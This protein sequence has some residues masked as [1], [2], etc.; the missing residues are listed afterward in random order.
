MN[1][2]FQY[3]IQNDGI[4]TGL[5]YPYEAKDSTCRFRRDDPFYQINDISI[6]P[7]N[8]EQALKEALA[9]KGPVAVAID[10]SGPFHHYKNGVFYNP[11]CE[12]NKFR[13]AVLVVGY[14]SE[15]REDFW[16]VKNSWGDKWGEQGYIKMARN[17]NNNC[18]IAGVASFPVVI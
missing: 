10:S 14:G 17:R 12:Q 9:L 11:D 2:A 6:L 15:N 7:K 16:L 4:N 5:T 3:I 8:D 13:H 18:G 1:E